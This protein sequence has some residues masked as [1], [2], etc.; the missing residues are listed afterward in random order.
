MDLEHFIKEIDVDKTFQETEFPEQL[1]SAPGDFEL[2]TNIGFADTAAF[3][4]DEAILTIPADSTDIR[5]TREDDCHKMDIG[6]MQ[7]LDGD[8]SD[9]WGTIL[10]NSHRAAVFSKGW[11]THAK[12][13]HWGHDGDRSRLVIDHDGWFINQFFSIKKC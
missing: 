10:A 4:K 9:Q 8:L 2:E 6:K 3:R 11:N 5:L 13:S 7:K 1:N 12:L